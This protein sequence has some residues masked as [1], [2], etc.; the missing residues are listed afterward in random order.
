MQSTADFHHH[1]TYPI[2]PHPDSLFEHAAAFHTTIDMF[3][4]HPAPRDRPVVRFLGG[5]QL[6]PARLLRG[7]EDLHAFQR[8]PLKAQVW[9]QLTPRWQRIGCEIGQTRVVDA[10]RRG[11]TQEHDA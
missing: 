11:L 5:R 9:Q 4:A 10:A 7:L 6:F 2:F 8:E 3:D 1:V